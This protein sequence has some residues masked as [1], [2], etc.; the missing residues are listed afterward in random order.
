[1]GAHIDEKRVICDGRVTIYQRTDVEKS[2]WQVRIKLPDVP[3]IRQSLKTPNERE[4]IKKATKLYEEMLYRHE[5][6]LTLKRYRFDEVFD[7]YLTFLAEEVKIGN[8]R[9]HKLVDQKNM[10]RYCRE[11][12]DGKFIDTITTGTP[13]AST[14]CRST[15]CR[16]P[17]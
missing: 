12:F 4:A 7:L 3:H 5:R 9:P 1:M 15:C 16:K 13:Y 6:G 11:Y 17:G 10:S 8:Q 14:S 2:H